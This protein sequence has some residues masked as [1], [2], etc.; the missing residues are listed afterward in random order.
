MRDYAKTV[1][2]LDENVGRLLDYLEENGMLENTVIFYTSDQG[3][4]MGEHGWFD[5]RFMYEESFSHALVMH[6]PKRFK[7]R[8][9]IDQVG[10]EHRFRPHYAGCSQVLRSHRIYKEFRSS[11]Y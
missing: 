8:G 10:A 1:Q 4:Y 11:R 2:S 9:E 5:K 3:F 7:K 6:L